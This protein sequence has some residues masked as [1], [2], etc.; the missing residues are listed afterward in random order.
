MDA[1]TETEVRVLASLI[2]KESTTPEY[3][4]LSLNA[5][6]LACN[7]KTNRDPVVSYDEAAVSEA[8]DSL[9]AN[10]LARRSSAHSRVEKYEHSFLEV[11]NLGRRELALLCTL[12]LRGPQTVGELK[13]RSERMRSFSDLEEVEACLESLMHWE[14]VP[15]AARLPRQPGMKEP[16][17]MHLLSGDAEPA[18]APV[19]VE[20]AAP[21]QEQIEALRTELREL[22]EEFARFRRQFES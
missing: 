14:P 4:P 9:R 21:L 16:R 6:M 13:D 8:I 3:Y 5:L 17:Y 10:R 20:R 22:R 19:A 15:L 11:F 18:A 2:E 1:L 7:Q 12:M